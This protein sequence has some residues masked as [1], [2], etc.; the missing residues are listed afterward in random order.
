MATHNFRRQRMDQKKSEAKERGHTKHQEALEL[1]DKL[2]RLSSQKRRKECLDLYKSP[3]NDAIRDC[4]H[5]SIVV[6][7][8][9]RCGDIAEAE[10]TVMSM[11]HVKKQTHQRDGH[12][13]WTDEPLPYQKVP[14][15]AW[16]ALLKGE[17]RLAN[18]FVTGYF[19]P[20]YTF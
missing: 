10:N 16:T 8:C 11:M 19:S 14:I 18:H 9:A 7:C 4:H 17:D 3:I 1:S 20:T 5:G 2:R 13:F 12:Y 15:Q 6:D